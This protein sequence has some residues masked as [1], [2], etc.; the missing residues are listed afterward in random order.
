M[1]NLSH[2][3]I[4]LAAAVVCVAVMKRVGF[5][6]VLG[7]LL[8]GIAIGPWGLR[9]IDDIASAQHLAEFGVVLL[10][11]VIGLELQPARLWALRRPVFGMGSAQVATTGMLLTI[12]ALLAGQALGVAVLIGLGLAMSSTALVLQL[13]AEKHELGA[14][15]GRASFAILLLQD[16]AVIP[17][18]AMVPLL[19]S[20]TGFAGMTPGLGLLKVVAVLALMFPLSRF[21]LRPVFMAVARTEVPE[22]FT[23]LALL[24]VV[25]TAWLMEAVGISVTLGA[26]LAG[27][28]LADSE[29][30]HEIETRL[31]PFEGLLLGLFF[32]SVGMSANLGLLRADP[33]GILGL[34]TGLILGKF[35]C[36]Y[37]VARAMQFAQI[38]ALKLAAALCQGGEFA[39]ILFALARDQGL[40]DS[41]AADTLML[42]VSLSM[43]ATPFVY[44]A[45]TKW[46]AR[47]TGKLAV[48]PY[49]EVT[50]TDHT[51]VIAGLGRFG[52]IAGRILRALEIPFTALDINPE[53]IEMSRRFGSKAY[54]G[55]ASNLDLLKSAHLEH[56]KV[57]IIA[58]DDPD[59]SVRTAELVR[60]HFPHV[61]ILARARNRQHVY[62]LM[63]I[64]VAFIERE[65][66]H[67]SLHLSEQLLV[68]L[69][70]SLQTARRAVIA[71]KRND[72]AALL[73][74][75]SI[76]K[77]EAQLIQTTKEA[78]AELRA[79]LE[80]D[81]RL[82]ASRE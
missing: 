47:I 7:Y 17:L 66:Y 9:L 80:L 13:L 3:A 46:S 77:D 5:A 18:L 34:V 52:Q 25:A 8:A 60:T 70:F 33:I 20:G 21:V 12:V 59:A 69:G 35:V 14:P 57:I 64:G 71:F 4:Y 74:A 50:S 38:N 41:P 29:Y 39:F 28:L 24:V 51:V 79:I 58:I 62:R 67:S 76:Y 16:L 61:E 40:L 81:P 78:A 37:G 56:A 1:N 53:H 22:L 44:A 73:K 19:A 54:Y 42:V 72:E 82:S 30:R 31:A 36:L 75:H 32:I 68:T 48:N 43:A 11:F 27:V 2:I 49:D 26:F 10:L 6:A 63:D 65:L 55:D 45:A 15:H 23:A